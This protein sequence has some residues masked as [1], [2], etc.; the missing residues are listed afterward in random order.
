MKAA[1]KEVLEK[2][3]RHRADNAERRI[4]DLFDVDPSRFASFS[5][6][7]GSILYDYSKNNVS[8]ETLD[9]LIDLAEVAGV[10]DRRA[11]LFA[12]K[13]INSTEDRAV[14]HMA[15][16]QSSG[17]K[18]MID[19]E[20]VMQDVE[21][22]RAVMRNFAE[23]V[24]SG[25]IA[26]RGGA[27]TDIVNIGIGG[28]D[29]GPAMV[30]QALAPFHDGPRTHFVS[31][32]DGADILDTL[33]KVEPSTTLF[34]VA[35]KTFTTQETMTNAGTARAWLAETLGEEAVKNHFVAL[36]T[37]LDKTKAFGIADDRAFGFWDW[38][39]GRYSVWSAIG[40]SVMLAI[41]PE[42]FDDFLAGARA[43]DDHFRTEKLRDNIPIIMGLIGIW[44]RNVC[45][46]ATHAVLPY[47]QHMARFP[48]Y[49]QQLD[50]ESNG[51]GTGL[52]GV[53]VAYETG[54]IVWGEPGTNGQHAFYQLIHQGTSVI[55]CDFLIAAK[56]AELVGDHH[57]KLIA[58]ALAQTEALMQGK[59]Q[60]QVEA[61]L[62]DQGL[63]DA[64]IADLA[65]HKV[66]P[67][68]RPTSTFLYPTL[69]PHTLGQLIALYEHKVFVQGTIW[70]IN[71]FDQWGVELGK[72]MAGDLL[73][74]VKGDAEIEGVSGST[75]GLLGAV[76]N[77]RG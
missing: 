13:H 14:Q 19:G 63:D 75:A 70:N 27:F 16:R 77:M 72:Q 30:T 41:G 21:V 62:R 55:P 52:D 53:P 5:S 7:C 64:A 58:N 50:M 6:R 43:V 74:M 42:K 17:A 73:P 26:G 4:V 59:T 57:A 37:A 20:N 15:L 66:F 11:D 34:I 61:E 71:S 8:E 51:K 29:L 45:G 44:H 23:G 31:N 67:G 28:S 9:L 3:E 68:N 10:E 60:L 2:L 76:S 47:D 36:S 38:V 24:R 18:V 1:A 46:Y 48:A 56:P 65:P 69:S 39:G 32:I 35:S 12:G 22:V 33:A 49:L 40:L 54:P 25:K